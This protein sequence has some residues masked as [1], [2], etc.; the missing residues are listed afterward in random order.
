MK[1][2]DRFL[3]LTAALPLISTEDVKILTLPQG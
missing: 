2:A 3:L 1:L